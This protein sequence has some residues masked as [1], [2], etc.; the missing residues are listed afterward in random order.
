MNKSNTALLRRSL[1]FFEEVR[2]KKIEKLPSLKQ[3]EKESAKSILNEVIERYEKEQKE[4]KRKTQKFRRIV[5]IVIVTAMLLCATACAVFYDEI[6]GFFAKIFDTH[7]TLWI[8]DSDAPECIENVAVL[9]FVPE[10]YVKE[11]TLEITGALT[12][13]WKNDSKS[14]TFTQNTINNFYHSVDTKDAECREIEMAGFKI[15]Q[16]HK[17]GIY[18]HV[19]RNDEYSFTL[20]CPDSLSGEEIERIISGI[21][22]NFQGNFE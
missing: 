14:I 18:A 5:A 1:I 7:T 16:T 2:I 12:T 17:N 3:E 10:Q 9:T 20:I 8:P 21:D 4:A 11:Q 22:Y 19:W 6:S 15:L 13:V